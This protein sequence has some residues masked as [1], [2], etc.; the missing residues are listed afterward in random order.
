MDLPEFQVLEKADIDSSRTPV[1]L[2]CTLAQWR[3][4]DSSLRDDLNQARQI[5][6][7]APGEKLP[8]SM[9]SIFAQETPLLME[10][11]FARKQW[12]ILDELELRHYFDLNV[13][14]I[15]FLKLQILERF[16]A[17]N[18][19]EGMKVFNSVC[20]VIYGQE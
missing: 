2:N 11:E 14:I 10:K 16:A 18:K 12:G 9:M 8:V 1:R 15:Y 17:F 7:N 6:Q 19:D 13:L 3:K 5:A 20:E 4:I